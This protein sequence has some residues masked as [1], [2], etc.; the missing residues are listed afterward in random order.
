LLDFSMPLTAIVFSALSVTVLDG[1]DGWHIESCFWLIS[2]T[3]EL[4]LIGRRKK[5]L[6]NIA[7]I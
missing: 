6:N 5:E 2:D 3:E 1:L 7:S 4:G